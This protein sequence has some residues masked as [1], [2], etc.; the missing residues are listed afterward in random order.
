MH[1]YKKIPE[2]TTFRSY[3]IVNGGD[4]GPSELNL[5]KL[6]AIV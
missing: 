2:N 3:L 4:I 1:T 5:S 6:H